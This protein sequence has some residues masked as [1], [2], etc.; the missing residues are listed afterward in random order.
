MRRK[1]SAIDVVK[2]YST[3]TEEVWRAILVKCLNTGNINRLV[4]I[5]YG[6]QAGLSDA[7]KKGIKNPDL[8]FWVI[9]RIRNLEKCAKLILR[10]KHPMPG[11]TVIPKYA[12]GKKID[13][14]MDAK[15]AKRRRDREFAAF[16]QRSSF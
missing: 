16:L 2:M 13:Y 11:D 12:K 15:E 10:K 6:M 3:L 5:R 7:V 1:Y 14:V 9:K 4:E 8:D